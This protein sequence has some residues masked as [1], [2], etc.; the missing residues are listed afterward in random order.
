MQNKPEANANV[1]TQRSRSRTA[2][3]SRKQE[4]AAAPAALPAA[5]AATPAMNVPIPLI[6]TNQDLINAFASAAGSLGL[7]QW[8]LL[9]KAGFD[10]NLLAVNRNAKF[11]GPAIEQMPNLSDE[12]QPKRALSTVCPTRRWYRSWVN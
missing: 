3:G 12:E 1:A 8:A 9:N 2:K 4:Q 10:V 6:F 5:P 11:P 7:D